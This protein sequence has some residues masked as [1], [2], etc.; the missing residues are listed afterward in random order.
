[1][2]SSEQN[3]RLTRVGSGTPMGDLLRR[4][5]YPIA[6]HAQMKNRDTLPVR[7]LGEDLVL[8]RDLSGAYGLIAAQRVTVADYVDG[9]ATAVPP[10]IPAARAIC[11]HAFE[12]RITT[13]SVRFLRN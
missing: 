8:Y 10:T 3:E 5:W 12:G 4:Y 6:T 9:V 2:L 1:M 11:S 13:R 7:L